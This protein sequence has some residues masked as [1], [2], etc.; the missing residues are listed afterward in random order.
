MLPVLLLVFII[1]HPTCFCSNIT[2]LS[3]GNSL[4]GPPY[5]YALILN[6]QMLWPFFIRTF[7]FL[8]L[9]L[10]FSYATTH[11][12]VP[13]IMKFTRSG[14]LIDSQVLVGGPQSHFTELRSIAIGR[15]KDGDGYLYVTDASSGDSFVNVYDRCD[16]N[17]HRKYL[18]TVVS[19]K[20]NQGADHAYGITF[21]SDGNIYASFQHTDSVL[22]FLKDSF[23]PMPFPITIREKQLWKGKEYYAGTFVQFGNPEQHN[24]A[25]QG[26]RGIARV[27]GSIWIANEDLKGVAVAEINTG[28]ITNII[29]VHNPISVLYDSNS[30]LVFISSKRKHWRGAVL[31]VNPHTYRKVAYFTNDRLNH[32]SG[33]AVHDGI[34][35]VASLTDG[36]ILTFDINTTKYLGKVVK[37]APGEIEQLMM[38]DC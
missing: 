14:I 10:F 36:E 22:R 23:D 37:K 1:F 25:E 15:H 26:V 7:R 3:N 12:E 21:D 38:S 9:Q 13:N 35:Y 4:D 17:G 11:D 24:P 8:L 30:D 27:H 33:M 6:K 32:P 5:M 31:A 28:L 18:D 2:I 29:V 20:I 16:K 34:L 19:T